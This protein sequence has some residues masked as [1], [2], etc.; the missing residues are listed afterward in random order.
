MQ[1][2]TSLTATCKFTGI[3]KGPTVFDLLG[4]LAI[5][6]MCLSFLSGEV[7]HKEICKYAQ[8]NYSRAEQHFKLN[9]SVC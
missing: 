4:F 7:D 2:Y 1:Q 6:I 8:S 9:M 5:I 3:F